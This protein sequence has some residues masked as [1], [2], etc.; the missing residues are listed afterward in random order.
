M[1]H[2]FVLLI[3]VITTN[4][5]NWLH[6]FNASLIPDIYQHQIKIITNEQFNK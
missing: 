2:Q 1:T 3:P 4:I 6:N 5:T